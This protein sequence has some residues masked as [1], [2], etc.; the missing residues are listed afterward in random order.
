MTKLEIL[1]S[2]ED[3]RIRDSWVALGSQVVTENTKV[4]VK[5]QIYQINIPGSGL[6]EFLLF[7]TEEI[8][9]DVNWGDAQIADYNHREITF[10]NN[11][12][13][14]NFALLLTADELSGITQDVDESFVP[15]EAEFQQTGVVR[16][17]ES[18]LTTI[19]S[20]IGI[21]FIHYEELEYS[22]EEI[23]NLMI[24]P[25]LEEYFKWFPK[26]L[27]K[28]Y[29]VRTTQQVEFEFPTGAYDV[30]HVGV[31]QGRPGGDINNTL[32]RYFDEVVWTAQ[33]PVMGTTGGLREPKRVM[34]DWGSMMM[35]RAVRQGLIN[36]GTRTHHHTYRAVN[37]KRYLVAYTNKPGT[38]QVHYALQTLD[39]EDS[40][41][42]RRPELRELARANVLRAFGTLRSQAKSDIPGSIDYSNWVSRAESMK[43]KVVAE[44]KDIVRYS[45]IIRGSM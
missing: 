18:E 25:A 27:I 8:I 30:I 41:F 24:K 1:S 40:E 22:R 31:V 10:G 16:I 33:N 34:N 2:Y 6:Y 29:P 20:D 28:T 36:Y 13:S 3:Y 12:I 35:D 39:W 21:P 14:P 11:I 45:G 26:T 42:P 9:G 23:L 43:E 4:Y 5:D 37:G 19:L 7:C 17:P 38:L 32:L 44:W 15:F